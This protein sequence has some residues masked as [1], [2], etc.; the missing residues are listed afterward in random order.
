MLLIWFYPANASLKY[1][2]DKNNPHKRI[3]CGDCNLFDNYLLENCG[4]RLAAFKPYFF[5]SFIRESLVKKPAFFN[6]GR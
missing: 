5:L 3:V 1:F 6:A 4:A 2:V